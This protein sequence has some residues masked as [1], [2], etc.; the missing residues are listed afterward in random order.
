MKQYAVIFTS[1]NGDMTKS[2][3]KDIAFFSSLQDAKIFGQ[4]IS[5]TFTSE[6]GM[7]C[8]YWIYSY[9]EAETLR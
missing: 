7:I 4:S 6:T 2:M 8:D 1:E 9:L 3:F 5:E